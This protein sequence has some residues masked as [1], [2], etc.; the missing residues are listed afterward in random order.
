M[1]HP[2]HQKVIICAITGN[3]TRPD[4]SPYLPFRP[5]QIADSALEAAEASAAIA[6]IHVAIPKPAISQCGS[7]CTAT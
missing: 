2:P 1:A 3:L 5:Q 6:Q 4:Q 7:I